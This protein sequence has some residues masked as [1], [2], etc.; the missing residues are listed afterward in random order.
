MANTIRT[1][2]YNL[3]L[4]TTMRNMRG[5]IRNEISTSQHFLAYLEM[6][7]RKRYVNGGRKI[8]A[9]VMYDFNQTGDIYTDYGYPLAA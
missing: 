2:T 8:D 1:E 7:G 3:L 4:T 5:R 6:R 9:A